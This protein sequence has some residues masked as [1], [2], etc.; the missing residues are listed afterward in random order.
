M[1]HLHDKPLPP[2]AGTPFDDVPHML[3][4]DYLVHWIDITRCWLEGD[5]VLSV[6]AQD[7]RVPGQPAEARN[8]W[9][10][11][12]QLALVLR[13]ERVDPRRRQRA[14]AGR[15]LPL[16]DPRHRGDDPG[17]RAAGQRL[18]RTRAR[19]RAHP[20]R[21]GGPVV[22]RRLRR[23]DGRTAHARSPRTANPR[24]RPST[25]SPRFGWVWPRRPPPRR[26]ARPSDPT[27]S[28]SRRRSTRRGPGHDR[29]STRCRSAP[30]ARI[31][32][33]GWQSWS[34]TTWYR[35]GEEAHRPARG[36]AAPDAVPPGH[37]AARRGRAGGGAARR[38]PRR[39]ASPVRA[40][41]DARRLVRGAL[42]PRFVA[43]RPRRG[44]GRLR[45]SRAGRRMPR[46][47]AMPMVARGDGA[48]GVRRPVRRGIRCEGQRDR[49]RECGA[50]GTATSRRSPPRTCSRTSARS[51]TRQLPVDVVQI[52]DGWSLGTGEWTAPNPRFGSLARHGR[53]HPRQRT[54]GRASG[55]RRSASVRGRT[56]LGSIPS[57]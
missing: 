47:R 52:D 18:R 24:T 10:A 37:A 30:D 43:R 1:T 8:P 25:C 29:R 41:R 31:Y 36:L 54:A 16:L 5:R 39:R 55:S 28:S 19:R 3:L 17:Q 44:R 38:R 22:H 35:R 34:P 4:S 2:L 21:P 49:T 6:S 46:L 27:A 14:H 57:G 15:R 11:S 45:R 42:D 53:R 48:G 23:D 40:L 12:L 7:S 51:R 13:R 33:E 26:A 50:R 56:S 32:A 20:L 9:H